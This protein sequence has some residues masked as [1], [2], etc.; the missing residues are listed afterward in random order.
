[1]SKGKWSEER[2]KAWSEKCRSTGINNAG[3]F[4]EEYLE[5]LSKAKK[6]HNAEYWT[7]EKRAAHALKMKSVVSSYPDSY[8][9]N[10]VSGRA[11]LYET[12]DFYGATKVKGTWELRVATY[13]NENNI[14]W[15]NKI[16]PYKYYW[17]DKW[18][19]YFPDFLL[20]DRDI[21]LEVKGFETDRDRAKWASVDKKLVVLRGIDMLSLDRSIAEG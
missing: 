10:N 14:K 15:T 1:M 20:L 17:N 13:L 3:K 16:E 19:L 6:K 2:K 9:K 21:L 11:R 5:N 8:S 12:V 4:T 18:H 7:D